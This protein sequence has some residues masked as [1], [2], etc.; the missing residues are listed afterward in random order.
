MLSS[1]VGGGLCSICLG[2][3]IVSSSF[4]LFLGF[5][6]CIGCVL[7]CL[8]CGSLRL[9]GGFL[10]LFF[11]FLLNLSNAFLVSSAAFFE[12]SA[13]ASGLGAGAG[14]GAGAGFAAAFLAELLIFS[15]FAFFLASCLIWAFFLDF[16]FYIFSCSLCFFVT[17]ASDSFFSL[18]A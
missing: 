16:A 11:S 12:A 15:L 8:F 1:L 4:T 2:L 3:G 17:A 9:V 18:I 6:G 10:G 7:L 13:A 14:A 5:F